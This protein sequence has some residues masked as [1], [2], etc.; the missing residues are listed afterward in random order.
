[1]KSEKGSIKHWLFIIALGLIV[2]FGVSSYNSL[3]ARAEAEEGNIIS[4]F[5]NRIL[6]NAK[7]EI[8]KVKDDAINNAKEEISN[9]IK[10]QVD[11]TLGTTGTESVGGEYCPEECT[12][13]CPQ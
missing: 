8:N 13:V 6:G 3:N 10:N 11:Q 5:I 7:D 12:C 1:M 2:F 9:S 4:N